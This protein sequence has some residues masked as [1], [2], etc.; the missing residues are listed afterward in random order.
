MAN[1]HILQQTDIFF[2]FDA[3]QLARVAALCD[4][5]RYGVGDW[6]FEEN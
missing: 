5:K 4:D 1:L 3:E 6:V 2:E